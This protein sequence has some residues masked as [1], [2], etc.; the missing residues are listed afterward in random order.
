V[1]VMER[2]DT[3]TN[4]EHDET[5]QMLANEVVDGS[6]AGLAIYNLLKMQLAS[7]RSLPE[8]R[9]HERIPPAR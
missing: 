3:D 5:L 9:E 8:R 6:I 7:I 4:T 2:Y 1:I